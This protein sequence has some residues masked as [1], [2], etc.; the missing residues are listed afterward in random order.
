MQGLYAIADTRTLRARAI[1]IVAFARAILLARPAA[2][3][4]RAK[5][6]PPRDLLALLRTLSPLCREAGVPFVVNDRPDLAALAGCDYAHVGQDDLP[7]DRVRRMAPGLRVGLST[8][9]SEQ[10]ARALQ[11]R[12]E[13]VAYG[14]VFPTASKER[15]DPVVGLAGLRE[16][17]IA[18]R[19]ARVPL[20]A[21]GGI[22]LATAV[23][24]AAV[25]D[26]SAVISGLLPEDGACAY[27]RHDPRSV[28]EWITM[29]ALALQAALSTPPSDGVARPSEAAV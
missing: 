4:L 13:Y 3:Q 8:H 23:D 15:P 16:A 14:P 19:R 6:E 21:I 27:S 25:A 26:A 28:L 7:M 17:A 2:L 12:P 11:A 9:T 20:V 24:V 1:D 29:R 5:A 22:T 10:L 18:A